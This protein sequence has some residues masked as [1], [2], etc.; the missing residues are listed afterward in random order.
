MF[1][2]TKNK[3]DSRKVNLMTEYA[4]GKYTVWTSIHKDFFLHAGYK[5]CDVLSSNDTI[6]EVEIVESQIKP[7]RKTSQET[8]RIDNSNLI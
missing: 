7:V 6:A 1:Y 8:D 4:A 2:I 5:I 3:R